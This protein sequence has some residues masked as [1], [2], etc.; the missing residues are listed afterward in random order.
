MCAVFYSPFPV[1]I[2]SHVWLDA[3]DDETD[4]ILKYSDGSL[5]EWLGHYISADLRQFN[6]NPDYNY[7]Y[8]HTDGKWNVHY[9][10]T[11]LIYICEA[12]IGE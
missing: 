4:G 7:Q 1:F 6:H 11:R 2:S 9:H 5:V 8:L 12:E 10:G 3:T